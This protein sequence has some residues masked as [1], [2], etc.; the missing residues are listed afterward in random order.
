MSVRG[1]ISV[2][3]IWQYI[4]CR[5]P[6]LLWGSTGLQVLCLTN[7]PSIVVKKKR[8]KEETFSF[9]SSVMHFTSTDHHHCVYLYHYTPSAPSGF[10]AG[11]KD[12]RHWGRLRWARQVCEAW[13]RTHS[14]TLSLQDRWH[15]ITK[16]LFPLTDAAV[17]SSAPSNSVSTM[18]VPAECALIR[19]RWAA[20]ALSCCAVMLLWAVTTL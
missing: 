7:I 11:S 8:K 13:L 12:W 15:D 4:H 20:P 17:L 2:A 5:G 10:I 9:L 1:S 14:H 18:S 3:N 16:Q 6:K 19:S